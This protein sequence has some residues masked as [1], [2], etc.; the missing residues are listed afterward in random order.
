MSTFSD[1][2]LDAQALGKFVNDAPDAEN[3]GQ[4]NG[5]VTNRTGTTLNNLRKSA[6]LIAIST[7]LAAGYADTS[8]TQAGIATSKAAE[9]AGYVDDIATAVAAVEELPDLV[10]DYVGIPTT[11]GATPTAGTSGDPLGG[12]TMY[13]GTFGATTAEGFLES[14]TVWISAIGTGAL[15]LDVRIPYSIPT[16]GGTLNALYQ[17]IDIAGVAS[18]GLKTFTAGTHFPRGIAILKGSVFDIGCATGGARVSFVVNLGAGITRTYGGGGYNVGESVGFN[19]V[20]L[21]QVTTVSKDQTIAQAIDNAEALASLIS[22]NGTVTEYTCGD[23]GLLEVAG[24]GGGYGA[25]Q[26]PNG[27]YP[28]LND[29]L[30]RGIEYNCAVGDSGDC[31]F[32]VFRNGVR[33]AHF[34]A[35]LVEGV[36]QF[37]AAPTGRDAI[38]LKRGDLIWTQPITGTVAQRSYT[39][40]GSYFANS[41][42]LF[43]GLTYT[44]DGSQYNRVGCFRAVCD[45]PRFARET[46]Q[47]ASRG[48]TQ[49]LR[50]TFPGVTL[51]K[52][53]AIGGAAFTCND[54]L[55]SPAAPAAS[56]NNWCAFSDYT[57][58]HRRTAHALI[59][60]GK[61]DNIGGIMWLSQQAATLPMGSIIVIDG[62]AAKL[63][64]YRG[65][66][67]GPLDAGLNVDLPWVPADADKILITAKIDR[68]ILTVNARNLITGQTATIT[69]Q[70]SSV[71]IHGGFMRGRIAAVLYSGTGSMK[72]KRIGNITHWARGAGSALLFQD[73]TA[74]ILSYGGYNRVPW[75]QVEDQYGRGNFM[76]CSKQAADSGSCLAQSAQDFIALL[77]QAAT[78]EGSIA[79]GTNTLT[80]TACTGRISVGDLIH[81]PGITPGTTIAAFGTGTGDVG[82]YTTSG[83][84]QTVAA[85]RIAVV[86]RTAAAGVEV[87]WGTGVNP[88]HGG[89][90]SDAQWYA[91]YKADTLAMAAIV[92]AVG[93]KFTVITMNPANYITSY[94]TLAVN[95]VIGGDLGDIDVID[96]NRRLATSNATRGTWGNSTWSW[97]GD[98]LHIDPIY[99]G[100]EV[101]NDIL[102]QRPDLAGLA[103]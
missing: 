30:L 41:N 49:T 71:G 8:T 48:A 59:E 90:E 15:R 91:N 97:N 61:A 66:N 87:F 52:K 81:G 46:A 67:P 93:G 18:T 4:A 42:Y 44:N 79:A 5:T 34:R 37:V 1:A 22:K 35:T 45:R 17:R 6:A 83:A 69:S 39:A 55:V 21:L 14:F 27:T 12:G 26:F 74:D 29:S 32:I 64:V 78:V 103:A 9:A 47:A 20:P 94:V 86:A 31:Y 57:N 58:A 82:T 77:P 13:Q 84:V 62:P 70:I 33:I 99:K 92:Q 72:W 89:G 11:Y 50:E 10:S 56:W 102:E 85:T 96:I 73:S 23:S 76:N 75:H 53:W 19:Y 95:N 101:A 60:M 7:A 38:A 80:V 88:R 63:R 28:V 2:Q 40:Q 3:P 24:W 16:S 25:G 43:S 100:T 54:G 36:K 68:E 65:G 51:P 98:T